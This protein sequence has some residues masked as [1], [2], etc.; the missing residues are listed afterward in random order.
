MDVFKVGSSTCCKT[1]LG[2]VPMFVFPSSDHNCSQM[3]ALDNNI[4]NERFL[5]GSLDA[6]LKG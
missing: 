5:N 6:N 4:Q 1:L 3:L 2:G